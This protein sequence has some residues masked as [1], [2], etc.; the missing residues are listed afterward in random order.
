MMPLVLANIG[1]ENL[2]YMVGGSPEVKKHLA[3]IGFVPGGMVSVVSS[4]GDSIIVKVKEAR[5]A[6]SAELARRI[7]VQLA[8]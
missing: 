2:I 5:V 3:D 6:I 4:I 8:L 7:M 1:E